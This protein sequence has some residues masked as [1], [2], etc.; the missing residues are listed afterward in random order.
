MNKLLLLPVTLAVLLL[1]AAALAQPAPAPAPVQSLSPSTM[2]IALLGILAG[3][4]THSIQTGSLFGIKTIPTTWL[5]YLTLLGGFLTPFVTTIS[6]APQATEVAWFN[7]LLA[8]LLGL[9]GVATGVTVKQA[10]DARKRG[11]TPPEPPA[12]SGSPS[13]RDAVTKAADALKP[14]AAHRGALRA[15]L[16]GAVSALLV[17]ALLMQPACKG[18][19]LPVAENIVAV[20]LADLQA[21]KSDSQIA[22]DVCAALGGLSATDAVCSGAEQLVADVITYLVDSGTLSSSAL[23]NAQAYQARHKAAH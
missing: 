18:S 5:P 9:G 19:A 14:P 12:T 2:V 16:V 8:G 7:A 3:Y 22:A 1:P 10:V 21:G 17:V 6:G 15:G 4:V 11:Q 23:A 20:V 13:E